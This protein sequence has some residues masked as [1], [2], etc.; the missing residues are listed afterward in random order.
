M[1]FFALLLILWTVDIQRTSAQPA[2]NGVSA[3]PTVVLDVSSA[4][5]VTECLIGFS[6]PGEGE[7]TLSDGRIE[8]AILEFTLPTEITE[9]VEIAAYAA[10][11]EGSEIELEAPT[12]VA[13]WEITP[14]DW[15]IVGG[16]V[17][18]DLTDAIRADL[19]RVGEA[20][21][22]VIRIEYGE[23]SAAKL[24]SALEWGEVRILV[25]PTIH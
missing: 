10:R 2:T 13:R 16:I 20:Q 14:L 5:E 18:L 8:E 24:Q 11:E 15:E 21:Q 3:Q 7:E 1:R 19:L 12:F 9:Y 4:E 23:V 22:L 25:G 17:R 6:L